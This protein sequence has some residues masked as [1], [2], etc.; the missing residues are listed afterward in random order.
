MRAFN[1]GNIC[2]QGHKHDD[3]LWIACRI[4]PRLRGNI[5]LRYTLVYFHLWKTC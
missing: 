3:Q 2:V 5:T 4:A 1:L